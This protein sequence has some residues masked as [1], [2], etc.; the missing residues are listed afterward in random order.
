MLKFLCE[1]WVCLFLFLSSVAAEPVL[2]LEEQEDCFSYNIVISAPEGEDYFPT[3]I[4]V[5]EST[6]MPIELPFFPE[7]RKRSFSEFIADNDTNQNR[8]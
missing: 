5:C 3:I 4:A 1:T 2:F 8:C 7:E 6:P